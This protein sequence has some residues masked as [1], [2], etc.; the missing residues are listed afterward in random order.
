M[1]ISSLHKSISEESKDDVLKLIRHLRDLRRQQIDIPQKTKVKR[2]VKAKKQV[3]TKQIIDITVD[4]LTPE[5]KAKL[6]NKLIRIKERKNG[7]KS[8]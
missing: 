4:K 2:G 6:L 1:N 8:R 5:E 3:L 7:R